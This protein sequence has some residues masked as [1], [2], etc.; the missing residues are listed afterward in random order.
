MKRADFAWGRMQ[1]LAII[2]GQVPSPGLGVCLPRSVP[3]ESL[4]ARRS[5]TASFAFSKARATERADGYKAHS[6]V[7]AAAAEAASQHRSVSPG[8]RQ[9]P[10]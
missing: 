9:L 1:R 5:G 2:T 3:A 6:A 4:L 8:S 7:P 10:S